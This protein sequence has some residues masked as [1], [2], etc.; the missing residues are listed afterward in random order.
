MR[1]WEALGMP[2]WGVRAAG[3]VLSAGAEGVI[4]RERG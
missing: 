1:W 4:L 3:E 2:A